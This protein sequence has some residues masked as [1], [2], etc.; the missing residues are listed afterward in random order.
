MGT[1]DQPTGPRRI[2]ARVVARL[3]LTVVMF[4]LFMVVLYLGFPWRLTK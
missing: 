3:V 4:L 2:F 1:D